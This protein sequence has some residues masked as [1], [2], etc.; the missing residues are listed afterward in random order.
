[1]LHF[2]GIDGDRGSDLPS[3]L[4]LAEL[5]AAARGE[6]E[7]SVAIRDLEAWARW[8]AR[9]KR[10]RGLR[11]GIDPSKLEQTGWGVVFARDAPPELREALTELLDHRRRQ[12]AQK[13]EIYYREYRGEDGYRSG[14][15]K[16]EF[17]KRCGAGP[18]PADPENVPY[19][20]LL[21]GGPEAI[22]F[23][24]QYQL[25][26]Q[27]GVGRLCFDT[28]DEY[29]QYARSVV[30]AETRGTANGRRAAFWGVKNPD[31]QATRISAEYLVEPMA[32]ELSADRPGWTVETYLGEEATKARL[33]RLCS[34]VPPALLFAAGHGLGFRA[35]KPR[36]LPHQGALLCQDWPGPKAWRKRIPEEHYFAADDLGPDARVHGMIAF[37]FACFGAGTPRYDSFPEPEAAEPRV[38]APRDF[39][40]RLPQRLLSHPQG[41]ALAVIGHID[42]AWG[43]SFLWPGAG[44]QRAAF[45][46]T[47]LRLTA[48]KPIGWALEYLGQRYAELAAELAVEREEL[49]LGKEEHVELLCDLWTARNDARNYVLLGDPA[50]RLGGIDPQ[51]T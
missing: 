38:L 26:V 45:L 43:F 8:L 36:Q 50:V 2:N 25:D 11:A 35:G 29:A 42:R 6:S 7:S 1:M 46:S 4:S 22:P 31:D 3:P 37:L 32:A 19:Y 34:D 30:R 40:S 48:G 5:A 10:K 12:A 33:A 24:F 51:F 41:G 15:T 49:E 28:L 27:Y 16:L 21:I 14:E 20:L 44:S 17:L 9:A 13:R 47:L 23:S 18:G 39:V